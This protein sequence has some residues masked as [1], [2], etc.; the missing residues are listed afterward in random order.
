MNM[1]LHAE[2]TLP[3]VTIEMLIARHGVWR[4]L[5]AV[6]AALVRRERKARRLMSNEM[7]EHLRRDVGLW[8]VPKSPRHWDVR[9]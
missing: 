5:R 1:Q 2:E 9:L 3:S 7:S 8:P 6:A 4:I